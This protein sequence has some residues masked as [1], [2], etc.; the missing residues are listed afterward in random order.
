M[1]AKSSILSECNQPKWKHGK[2]LVERLA[3]LFIL[4]MCLLSG[5]IGLARSQT[6]G[7]QD[8]AYLQVSSF[9]INAGGED[10]NVA[11]DASLT[12]TVSYQFWDNANPTAVWQIWI[13]FASGNAVACIWNGTPGEEPGVSRTDSSTFSAP[14]TT[15]TYTISLMPIALYSCNQLASTPRESWP[16]SVAV[17]QVTVEV[18]PTC[19]YGGTYP[20]C[21]PRQLLALKVKF[22][23]VGT[24]AIVVSAVFAAVALLGVS[25]FL[26][27]I[28]QRVKHRPKDRLLSRGGF[29]QNKFVRRSA[30]REPSGNDILVRR[31]K[32]DN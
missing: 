10:V 5:S 8:S 9:D 13:I 25:S 30:S 4:F 24:V 12:A 1:R 18:R 6:W 15:G 17:G 23:D 32:R 7:S 3:T 2:K 19:P 16:A 28:M 22:V 31:G 27:V 29:S 21:N 26:L 11:P 20:N 14:A